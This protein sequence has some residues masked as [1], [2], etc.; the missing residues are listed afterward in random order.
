MIYYFLI[1]YIAFLRFLFILGNLLLFDIFSL[2]MFFKYITNINS[3]KNHKLCES[4][5]G[6][7]LGNTCHSVMCS[8]SILTIRNI[9]YLP[10]WF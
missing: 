3:E 2:D 6:H 7:L 4:Y 8:L 1:I 5:S 10:F 9:G